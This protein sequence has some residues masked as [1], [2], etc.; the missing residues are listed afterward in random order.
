MSERSHRSVPLFRRTR[1]AK[2]AVPVAITLASLAAST[3][4]L[5]GAATAATDSTGFYDPP[6]GL[7]EK[8]GALVRT[9]SMTLPITPGRGTRIMYRSTDAN[10]RPVAV[11]GTYIEPTAAYRGSGPRPLVTFAPGTQ[12]QADGCAPS[13]GLERG[14]LSRVQG[15]TNFGYEVPGISALVKRGVAVVVTDYVGLGTTDRVHTYMNRLDQG[16]AVLDAARAALRVPGATVTSESPVGA[17][18]YS[19][20]GAAAGAAAELARDYAPDVNLKAAYV[21]GPPAD[22]FSVMRSIDGTVLT[23]VIGYAVN[24]FVAA[25]PELR[26]ILDAEVTPTGRMALQKLA[27]QCEP[28]SMASFGFQRTTRW[29]TSGASIFRLASANPVIAE[30]VDRQRLGRVKPAVPVEVLTGTR[31]DI[32]PH[33]QAKQLAADWCALGADVTYVGVRQPRSSFGTGLNH[34]SIL[35]THGARTQRWLLDRLAGS[36]A[37]SN[38]AA[39]PMLP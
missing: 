1:R 18:G 23:G 8:N 37:A 24:G 26:P 16:H 12:G 9:A 25:Y 31:D 28:D 30:V 29:T 4:L 10:G 5:A 14:V 6:T 19:Q 35:L 36:P 21:G 27:A 32:V 2:V 11:T 17:Y 7:P 34:V 3:T 39:L 33:G 15:V 13:Y 22:L 38:C 20:G